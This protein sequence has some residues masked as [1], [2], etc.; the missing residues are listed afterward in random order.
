MKKNFS[1]VLIALLLMLVLATGLIA[2]DKTTYNVTFDLQDG[3]DPIVKTVESGN[4]VEAPKI[5]NPSYETFKGWYLDAEGKTAW[6]SA[7][8]IKSDL[9]VYACWT[10]QTAKITFKGNYPKSETKQLNLPKGQPLDMTLYVPERYGYLFNGWFKDSD[11]TE[12]FGETDIITGNTTLYAGW[13]ADPDHVHEYTHTN[14]EVTCT[15]D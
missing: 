5:E 9:T 10:V 1:L 11:C 13:I 4:K 15:K 3:S 12:P 6:N 8:P 14:K 2:C 7:D